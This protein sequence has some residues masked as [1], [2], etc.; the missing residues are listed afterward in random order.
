MRPQ[1]IVR[2]GPREPQ[3]SDANARE[4]SS[5]HP[6]GH[7]SHRL[8]G[9]PPATTVSGVALRVP[10]PSSDASRY[11]HILRRAR[12]HLNARDNSERGKQGARHDEHVR[13]KPHAFGKAPFG[14]ENMRHVGRLQAKNEERRDDYA[15]AEA[16]TVSDS[17][18][19][20]CYPRRTSSCLGPEGASRSTPAPAAVR[21]QARLPINHKSGRSVIDPRPSQASQTFQHQP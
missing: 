2:A 7:E 19:I 17:V 14:Q 18:H 12:L 16:L 1:S 6:A 3:I 5:L 20:L 4:P 10:A 11:R 8:A 13:N 9:A 21:L 15:Y